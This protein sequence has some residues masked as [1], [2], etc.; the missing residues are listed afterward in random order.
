MKLIVGSLI[1]TILFLGCYPSYSVYINNDKSS[2]YFKTYPSIESQYLKS[3]TFYDS[4]LAIKVGQDGDY[5]VYKLKPYEKFR[6]FSHV[7]KIPFED[8]IPFKY[9][10][11]IRNGD[12]ITL[13]NKKQIFS[14]LKIKSGEHSNKYRVYYI[15]LDSL[16][17]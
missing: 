1:I 8:E 16:A 12:T 14:L 6:M 9:I 13:D 15:A 2:L 10:E 11:F 4:I 5:G 7:G 3:S 17:K